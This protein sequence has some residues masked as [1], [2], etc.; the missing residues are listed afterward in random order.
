MERRWHTYQREAQRVG[1]G[2]TDTWE[3]GKSS[4]LGGSTYKGICSIVGNSFSKGGRWEIEQDPTLCTKADKQKDKTMDSSYLLAENIVDTRYEDLPLEVIEVTKKRILDTTG[5]ILA[6]S[7]LGENSVKEIVELVKEDGGKEESTIIGFGGKVVSWMAAFANGAMAHQ[8]DYDDCYDIGVVHPGAATVPAALAIAERQGSVTGKEFITAIALGSDVVCRLSYPLTKDTFEYAWARTGTLG[9]FGATAS[10][11]KL[12]GLDTTQMVSAFGLVLHQA[13]ISLEATYTPE[14][15][16]RAIRDGF[17]AKAGVFSAVLANK[18]IIGD[19][20][21]LDGKYGL[22]NACW[23]GDSDPARVTAEIGKKFAGVDVSFKPWPCC[24]N[25]HGFIEATL[26]LVKEHDIKSEDIVEITA[27]S[28]GM[29]KSYYEELDKRRMPKTSIDARFSLPFVLGV[30]VARRNV[31]LEDFTLE[32]RS[33]PAAL[34]VAQRVKYRFDE[35]YKRPGIEIG[36]V[37]ITVKSGQKYSKEV[38]FAYGH[39]EN[40][41][42]KEDLAAKFRDCASHSVTSLPRDRV[43]KIIETLNRLEEVTDMGQVIQLLA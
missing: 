36:L 18:G 34:E 26:H 14:S 10:A 2:G 20:N 41:I 12:L 4:T 43:D 9:K 13:T 24:R 38:I 39:P 29:R 31:M 15:D 7:T 33:N 37:E 42:S 32:G 11:G 28:G 1:P 35:R 16:V 21:S 27:V 6:A 3:H 5:V 30:A 8:L 19:K 40:P 23:L 22:Y 25:L 17:V